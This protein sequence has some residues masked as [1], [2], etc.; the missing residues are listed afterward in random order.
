MIQ[1]N[2]TFNECEK[3]LLLL[4]C[5]F[6]QHS[7]SIT[8][9]SHQF[10]VLNYHT[11]FEFNLVCHAPYV[12]FLFSLFM[13]IHTITYN[14]YSSD[15]LFNF[16]FSGGF[17]FCTYRITHCAFLKCAQ[18]V[19]SKIKCYFPNFLT[20]KQEIFC[21]LYVNVE[22][23]LRKIK[24]VERLCLVVMWQAKADG[25][26]DGQITCYKTYIPNN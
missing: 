25:Q 22:Y 10:P 14:S 23:D 21:L 13:I 20:S 6:T 9:Y 19:K 18:P 11:E 16:L 2:Y 26:L 1:S 24:I 5:C 15:F 12:F 7:T 3:A 4:P 17:S 8:Q